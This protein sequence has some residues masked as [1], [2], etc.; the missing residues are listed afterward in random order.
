VTLWGVRAPI[1]M[2]LVASAGIVTAVG[3]LSPRGD[4]ADVP[5]ASERAAA[6]SVPTPAR[7]RPRLVADVVADAAIR[8]ERNAAAAA[9]DRDAPEPALASREDRR[10]ASLVGLEREATRLVEASDLA[11]EVDARVDALEPLAPESPDAFERRRA[12]LRERLGSEAFLLARRLRD[13]YAG[14]VYPLGFP[15]ETVV[16]QERGWIEALPLEDREVMLRVAL[17]DREDRALEP[18]EPRFEGFESPPDDLAPE[19]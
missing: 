5:P 10:S 7:T 18:A 17:E 15:V 11:A 6:P 9:P 12:E 2:A 14:V 1:W 13:L 8:E 19:L 16:A 3:T 4:R